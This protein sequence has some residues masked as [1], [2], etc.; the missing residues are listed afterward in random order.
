MQRR[1]T[2]SIWLKSGDV[3][4]WSESSRFFA[5]MGWIDLSLL[6]H[7]IFSLLY[8]YS[9]CFGWECVRISVWWKMTQ[10][11]SKEDIKRKKKWTIDRGI[12]CGLFERSEKMEEPDDY[13]R[14]FHPIRRGLLKAGCLVR[15]QIECRMK[16]NE[17]WSIILSAASQLFFYGIISASF[18]DS[19]G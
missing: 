8:S 9:E 12:I 14:I 6:S 1:Q 15:Q 18:A 19:I 7:H 17:H 3:W 4:E 2:W 5:E 13:L 10:K 16:G 11:C